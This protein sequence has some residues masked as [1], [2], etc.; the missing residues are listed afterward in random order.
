MGTPLTEQRVRAAL[1]LAGGNRQKA[2]DLLDVN[3]VTVWRAMRK[4]GISPVWNVPTPDGCLPGD[5]GAA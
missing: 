2:A 3:R 5:K 1:E 4:F